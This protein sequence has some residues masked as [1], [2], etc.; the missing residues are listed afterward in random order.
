MISA[1]V[2][3]ILTI[4]STYLASQKTPLVA[5]SV[6]RMLRCLVTIVRLSI[7]SAVREGR[8]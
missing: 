4:E 3:V 2:R 6:G 1:C 7:L 8:V 5:P